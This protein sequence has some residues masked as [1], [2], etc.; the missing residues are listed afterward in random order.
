MISRLC[1]CEFTPDC[2]SNQW[3]LGTG[4]TKLVAGEEKCSSGRIWYCSG[5]RGVDKLSGETQKCHRVGFHRVCYRGVF[6]SMPN[7]LLR[8]GSMGDQVFPT[9]T[10]RHETYRCLFICQLCSVCCFRLVLTDNIFLQLTNV[11]LQYICIGRILMIFAKKFRRNISK[12][13]LKLLQ[14]TFGHSFDKNLLQQ[15]LP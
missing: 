14:N 13:F 15:A 4:E 12:C 6:R 8:S 1:L 5:C 2:L 7:M 3:S 10:P 9:R 11:N